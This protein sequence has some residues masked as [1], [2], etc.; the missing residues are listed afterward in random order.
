MNLIYTKIDSKWLSEKISKIDS[1]NDLYREMSLGI[2]NI[3]IP[4]INHIDKIDSYIKEFNGI[5]DELD[6]YL[7]DKYE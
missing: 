5:G 3:S 4:S 2:S 1:L 6:R 7:K